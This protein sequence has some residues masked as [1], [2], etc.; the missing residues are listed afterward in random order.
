M[1]DQLWSTL[2][3]V[4]SKKSLS[5]KQG[6]FQILR[7]QQATLNSLNGVNCTL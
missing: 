2:K 7:F 3:K 6:G 1:N 5:E 4:Y